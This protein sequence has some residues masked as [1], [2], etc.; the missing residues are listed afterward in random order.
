M[1]CPSSPAALGP[2]VTPTAPTDRPAAVGRGTFGPNGRR[3][4]CSHW[5][6]WRHLRGGCRSTSRRDDDGTPRRNLA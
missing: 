3:A 5:H 1:V 6:P 4:G 2:N